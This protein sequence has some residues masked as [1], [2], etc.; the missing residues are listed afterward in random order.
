MRNAPFSRPLIAA[1][2][3][4]LA[5][6]VL[7]GGAPAASEEAP[8]RAEWERIDYPTVELPSLPDNELALQLRPSSDEVWPGLFFQVSLDGPDAVPRGK[9]LQMQARLHYP[10]GRAVEARQSF[11]IGVSSGA[12]RWIRFYVFPWSGN[13]LTEAWLEL[14]V[15]K[16]TYW[17]E[18]P[19]GF[20]RNPADPLPPSDP[21]A[22]PAD[23]V[24][25]MKAAPKDSEIVRWKT[26]AYDFGTIQNGWKLAA[27]LRGL[28]ELQCVVKLARQD[29]PWSIHHPL[30][31]VKVAMDNGGALIPDQTGSHI[32]FGRRDREDEFTFDFNRLT[33]RGWGDL[34]VT[35]DG[36]ARSWTISMGPFLV[37][38][39]VDRPW[40]H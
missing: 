5:G 17:Y 3:A 2:C 24:P 6:A 10:D 9:H 32:E 13:T 30:T 14:R 40:N 37:G 15:D 36:E 38:E 22:P 19:Y 18:I 1:A 31:D 34:I 16:R 33:G 29:G 35:V 25:A 4:L 39:W 21:K 12:T 20:T 11:S 26:I 23:Y 27:E 7:G 8:R 28:G